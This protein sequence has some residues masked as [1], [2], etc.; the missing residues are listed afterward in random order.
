MILLRVAGMV[1]ILLIISMLVFGLLYLAPGDLVKNLIGNR[2]A[3]PEVIA[4]IRA[5]YHLDD[6]LSLQY[7]RWLTRALIGDFGQSIRMQAP[8]I[9]VIASR[10]GVTLALCALAFALAVVV[11][12]PLGVLSAVRPD[13][14]LDRS[15]TAVSLVGLSAPSFAIGLLLLYAFAYYLPIFP[16]YGGGVGPI[17]T[18][19]HLVLPSIALALGLGAILMRLTRTTVLRELDADYILFARARGMRESRVN[20]LALRNAAIPITTSA[21]LVLTYLIGGT[22]LV[23][24][25]FALPGLGTLLD[26]SVLYKDIGVVQALTLMVALL[27]AVITLVVDLSY[28]LL[29]PR[30]RAKELGR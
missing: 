16:V 8:V 27:I 12:V 10:T 4:A 3:S 29:D 22:I 30:V 1:A 18:L 28:L 19:Y 6:P 26:S 11:A 24:T 14:W 15:V 21:G 13:G 5:Q 2:P 9:D 23:E 7:W 17:D 25:I 20:R